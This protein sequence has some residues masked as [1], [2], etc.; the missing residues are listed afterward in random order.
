M[1]STDNSTSK[2]PAGRGR[3]GKAGR[4]SRS[5]IV[6]AGL[7]VVRE[8]GLEALTIRRVAQK[9]GSGPMSLYHHVADRDDLL[10]GMLDEVASQLSEP[11]PE[12]DPVEELVSVFCVLYASM[13]RDPWIVRCL[14]DGQPGSA[15]VNPLI[16]RAALAFEALG[17]EGADAGHAFYSLLHYTYGEVL[18]MD[19]FMRSEPILVQSDPDMERNFPATARTVLAAISSDQDAEPFEGSLRRILRSLKK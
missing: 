6:E 14:I 10:A 5:R 17:L 9:L 15:H 3:I 12:T 18:V 8:K 1:R 4:L 7:S 19:A 16:E 2:K 13:R 11:H